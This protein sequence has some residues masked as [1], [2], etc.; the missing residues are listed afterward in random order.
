MVMLEGLDLNLFSLNERR[1]QQTADK[2]HCAVYLCSHY[3]NHPRPSISR[4][5]H[6][7]SSCA[8]LIFSDSLLAEP[9]VALHKRSGRASSAGSHSQFYCS[10]S[11][12][13]EIIQFNNSFA[14]LG[15]IHTSNGWIISLGNLRFADEEQYL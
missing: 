7:E 13:D 9:L 15:D 1:C 8:Y 11:V 5:D 4:L 6:A 2:F 14:G 3:T 12:L 10:G